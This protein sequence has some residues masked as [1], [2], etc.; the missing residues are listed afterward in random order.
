MKKIALIFSGALIA[1]IILQSI[2]CYPRYKYDKIV[3]PDTPKNIAEINSP[4]DDYNISSPYIIN[5]YILCFS[6]NRNSQGKDFDIVSVSWILK[7]EMQDGSLRTYTFDE[8]GGYPFFNNFGISWNSFLNLKKGLSKINSQFDEFGPMFYTHNYNFYNFVH[9]LMFAS[10]RS[11]DFDIYYTTNKNDTSFE[12]P[13]PLNF[14]NSPKNDLYP[15]LD[16]NRNRLY[17]CS[18]RSGNYD[19]YFARLDLSKNDTGLI[20]RQY[21]YENAKVFMTTMDLDSLFSSVDSAEIVK[22][23]VLSSSY[24]DKCPMVFEDILV[25]ASNRP[26]GYGGYDLYYSV[27][28]NGSWSKP[29]NF[30]PKINTKYDEYRPYL[31]EKDLLLFSSNRPGGKGGFDLYMVGVSQ[32]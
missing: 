24:E 14:I 30:G 29:V 20:A 23:D 5:G 1:I 27:F 11:G 6:S 8:D 16:W 21:Y 26:G 4:F 10:D 2:I 28:E 3:Y 32:F 9:T 19:I 17:F 25:F 7:F 13:K 31:L 12:E 15:S 18:D 22:E